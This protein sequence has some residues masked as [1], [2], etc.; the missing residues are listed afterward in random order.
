MKATK[1]KGTY[2]QNNTKYT[3]RVIVI[4]NEEYC[5]VLNQKVICGIAVH[6]GKLYEDFDMA[7]SSLERGLKSGEIVKI[8]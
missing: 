7:Y 4:K 6:N 2:L 5:E 8:A 1:F 3:N